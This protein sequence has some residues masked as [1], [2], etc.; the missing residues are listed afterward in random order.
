MFADL[1]EDQTASAVVTPVNNAPVNTEMRV[2]P[3]PVNTQHKSRGGVLLA[4]LAV[5]VLSMLIAQTFGVSN[6]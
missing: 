6:K 4:L 2:N 1:L 5:L 3:N